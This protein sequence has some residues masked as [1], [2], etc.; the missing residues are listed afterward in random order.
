MTA[1]PTTTGRSSS[2]SSF[3]PSV[4]G[5]V[6]AIRF[7]KGTGNGGT[8]TGSLWSSTGTRL[9]T[10]TFENETATGWQTL[11]L[12]TP[13]RG[14][15]RPDVCR[16]VLRAAGALLGRRRLSSPRPYTQG[17]LTVPTAGNGRYGTARAAGSRPG[18][19]NS[20]NYW[21]GVVFR[22]R[23]RV[24]TADRAARVSPIGGIARAVAAFGL[25]CRLQWIAH[26]YG[27]CWGTRMTT[28]E[29]LGVAVVGAGYWGPNLIRNFRSAADWDLRAVC[30]L[31]T[32]RAEAVLGDRSGV[33]VTASLDELLARDDID[34]VA[35]ATPAR[36]HQP[37]AVAGAAGGQARAGR[38]AAGRQRGRRARDG[39]RWRRTAGSTL[40]ADHTYCYT[41]VVQKIRELVSEGALGEIL[42]VDSVR[43]NLGLIQPDVDVFWDLAPHDLS[44]LDYVLPGR[45]GPARR[46]RPRRRPARRRQGLRRLPDA[47][48]GQRRDGA[49]ARQLA[50]PDQDP[51]DGDRRQRAH[52]GLGRP[53]PAAAAERLRPWRRPRPAVGRLGRTGGRRP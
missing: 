24:A 25:R 39:R 52:P 22:S 5:Q 30:D 20:S 36:T 14:Q 6:T 19:W 12:D 32:A 45:A 1:R 51:P 3:T 28:T 13:I 23:R 17:P 34:A 2:G 53:Q 21:V 29:R 9:A 4:N 40:M 11:I 16:V 10:G 35:I 37:I 27:N 31:D 42:F 41:P 46:L 43:I 7:Y 50:Q 15:R 26:L 48:A 44:I 47:A 8:H 18:T 49:R 33:D 38:E